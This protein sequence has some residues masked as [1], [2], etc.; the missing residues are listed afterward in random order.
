VLPHNREVVSEENRVKNLGEE[1]YR[2]LRK[3]LQDPVW[4]TVRARSLADFETP[5]DIL[6]LVRVG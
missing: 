5:D 6:N 1:G 2:S 4:Y 3:M